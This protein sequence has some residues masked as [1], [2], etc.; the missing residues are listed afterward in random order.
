SGEPPEI[1]KGT[2][3]CLA[4]KADMIEHAAWPPG[5][6]KRHQNHDRC[7]D[8]KQNARCLIGVRLLEQIAQIAADKERGKRGYRHKDVPQSADLPRY[9]VLLADHRGKA[10]LG[11]CHEQER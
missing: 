9:G 1:F 11:A 2:P 4:L 10:V 6:V 5:G 8:E 3:G 7:T